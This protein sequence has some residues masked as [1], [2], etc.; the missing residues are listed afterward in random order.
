MVGLDLTHMDDTLISNLKSLASIFTIKKVYFIHVSKNLILPEE[1]SHAYPDLLAPVDE[2]IKKEITHEIQ[3]VGLHEAFSYEII[4]KEGNSQETILRWCKIKDIDLLVM[5]RKKM[6]KC[7]GSLVKN[8]TQKYDNPVLLL[9]EASSLTGLKK[10][11]LP[12]DFSAYSIMTIQ[13][14]KEISQ[15]T[16]GEIICCHLYEV[17]VGYSK[18][19]KSFEEFSAIMLE[20]AKKVYEKFIEENK[21]PALDCT[22]ILKQKKDEVENILMYSMDHKIDLIIIGSRGRTQSA[23][24][25]LGSVA[26]KMVDSNNEIPMLVLKKK[27][28]SMGFLE[29]LFKI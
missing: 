20:N 15:K 25:L 22:F 18:T 24:I 10:I 1:V 5:G 23:A 29:A 16:G 26:E 28:E 17:P 3:T 27:G 13:L 11:L 14:A 2:T 12:I 9:P 21:L 6:I 4:V 19:G 7:S 8:L